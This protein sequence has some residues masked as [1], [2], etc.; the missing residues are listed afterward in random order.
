MGKRYQVLLYILLGLVVFFLFSNITIKT[1]SN[2][3]IFLLGLIATLTVG[4]ISVFN[5]LGLVVY[6]FSNGW[7]DKK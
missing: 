2:A 1:T 6:C 7:K 5:L 3:T 4:M